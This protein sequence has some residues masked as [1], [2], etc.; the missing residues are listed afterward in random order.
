MKKKNDDKWWVNEILHASTCF[1]LRYLKL[2]V[3]SVVQ[4]ECI[5]PYSTQS[6]Q[7]KVTIWLV[8]RM[9]NNITFSYMER[10]VGTDLEKE[11]NSRWGKLVINSFW[12]ST[13]KS[14]DSTLHAFQAR[15]GI[16]WPEL[17]IS[18]LKLPR[19]TQ[20]SSKCHNK[21]KDYCRGK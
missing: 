21:Y 3:W 15:T 10:A 18:I 16:L 2:R 9:T 1:L 4:T 6:Q 11:T 7:N 13:K 5:L 20:L 19:S 8:P 17:E 12:C 14:P